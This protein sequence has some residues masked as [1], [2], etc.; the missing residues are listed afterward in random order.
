MKNLKLL[1]AVDGGKASSRT[2]HYVGHACRAMT[3]AAPQ[4][5]L[6][7]VLPP[8]PPYLEAGDSAAGTPNPRDAFETESRK[9]AGH[10]LAECQRMLAADGVPPGSV[11][12]EMVENE[13][14]VTAQIIGAA[15]RLGCDTVVVG[16]HGGSMVGRFVAGS[17]V[18]H[19]LR[20]PVGLT[21]WV[22]E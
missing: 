9:T 15:Y 2:I 22:V 20:E 19:L 17:V 3:E 14:N 11:T 8:L 21:I 7:H 18:E 5:V 16:R 1:V 13:G 4:V 6:F 12:V 10:M